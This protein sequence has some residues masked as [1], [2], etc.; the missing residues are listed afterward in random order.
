MRAKAK[1]M[2]PIAVLFLLLLFTPASSFADGWILMTPDFTITETEIT[3]T[4]KWVVLESFATALQC[5]DHRSSSIRQIDKTRREI[6]IVEDR[7]SLET[8]RELRLLWHMYS[9]SKCVLS[10]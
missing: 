9:N 6:G 3:P 8:N 7:G 1:M 5:N 4:K 2:T 10:R